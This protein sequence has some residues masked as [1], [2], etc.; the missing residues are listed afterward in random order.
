MKIISNSQLLALSH[1]SSTYDDEDPD[2]DDDDKDSSSLA[3]LVCPGRV[4][5]KTALK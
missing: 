1:S 4:I 5:A 3:N 2:R